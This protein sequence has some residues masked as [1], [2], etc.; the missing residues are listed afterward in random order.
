MQRSGDERQ[1]FGDE[2]HGLLNLSEGPFPAV[3]FVD[4]SHGKYQRR[5]SNFFQPM[6]GRTK[7]M[8]QAMIQKTETGP[9]S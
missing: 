4:P 2:R 9:K 6:T 1:D 8:K 7:A 3:D 5:F